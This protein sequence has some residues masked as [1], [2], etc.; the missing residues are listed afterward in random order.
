MGVRDTCMSPTSRPEQPRLA[1]VLFFCSSWERIRRTSHNY[2]LPLPD[3]GHVHTR[4]PSQL[5]PVSATALQWGLL[6]SR[7]VMWPPC[8]Q[9]LHH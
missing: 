2:P 1:A 6:T 3:S 5:S 9:T 4:P 8:F 7:P